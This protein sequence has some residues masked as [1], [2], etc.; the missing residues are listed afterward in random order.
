MASSADCHTNT[1]E[2]TTTIPFCCISDNCLVA[3]TNTVNQ[4]LPAG[5]FFP[6]VTKSAT[7]WQ[8]SSIVDPVDVS[9]T[10]KPYDTGPDQDTSQICATYYHCR[11]NFTQEE[12]P[13]Y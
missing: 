9:N 4:N 8:Q 12:P 10:I 2:D 11:N 6:N 7:I 3:N 1:C 5:R 13:L